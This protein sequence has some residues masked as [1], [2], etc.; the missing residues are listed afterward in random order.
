MLQVKLAP[1]LLLLLDGL[2]V[3]EIGSSSM[4]CEGK[5]LDSGFFAVRDDVLN[6]S[7]MLEGHYE[8]DVETEKQVHPPPL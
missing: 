1:T 6:G 8:K 5:L 3:F 4:F 2:Q 7:K